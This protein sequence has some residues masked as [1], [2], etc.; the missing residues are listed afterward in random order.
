M[1]DSENTFSSLSITWNIKECYK[2][3][4]AT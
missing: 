1:G 3:Q 2:W 4:N